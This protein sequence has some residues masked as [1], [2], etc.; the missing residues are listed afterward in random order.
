VS[1]PS[2][3][4][5][6][7]MHGPTAPPVVARALGVL[8]LV[9]GLCCAVWLAL[10]HVDRPQWWVVAVVAA[11]SL[12]TGL[13][14]VKAPL[15]IPGRWLGPVLFA[16]TALGSSAIAAAGVDDSAF[17][18]LYLCGGP[19]VF[20]FFSLRHAL[21]H[22]G[23]A[24]ACYATLLIGDA[25]HLGRPELL[26]GD[27]LV[28]LTTVVLAMLTVGG[29]SRMVATW[30]HESAALL[31]RSFEEAQIGVAMADL[32]M[33]LH[34]V[35]PAF[36]S[37]LGRSADELVGRS[38]IEFV[39]PDEQVDPSYI[40]AHMTPG[41]SL[42]TDA[43]YVRP[44]GSVV[45][46]Q[47][48]LTLIADDRG[49]PRF[50]LSH[51]ADITD[52]KH[53]VDQL[54]R[55]AAA[56]E[57]IADLGR[58]ALETTDL[59]ELLCR[60]NRMACELLGCDLS[61]VLRLQ[62]DGSLLVASGH[63]FEPGEIGTLRALPGPR[64]FGAATSI[65][66]E[67]LTVDRWADEQR[68][69]IPP[70]LARHGIASS[71]SAPIAGWGGPWGVIAAHSRAERVFTRHE[72][73]FVRSVAHILASAVSRL[74]A[75]DD[76]R[77]RATHDPLTGLANRT[78]FLERLEAALQREGRPGR[79]AVLL[80]DLDE[81]KVVNDSL[82]HRAGDEVLVGL[83]ERLAGVVRVGDT[84]ARLG[85]DE[86]VVLFE[87]VASEDEALA[88]AER[89]AQAWAEPL[90]TT[91]GAIFAS[92]SMG[93]ALSTH[94]TESAPTLLEQADAAMYRAKA[95][96]RGGME[97]FD[98]PMR[99]AALE[100]LELE[101]DL[102][103]ALAHDELWVAYQPVMDL[104][105]VERPAFVEALLRWDHPTRGS[106]PPSDFIPVAEQSG[107]ITELGAFVVRR[108]C[109]DVAALRQDLGLPRLGV[110][111]NLSAR[112]VGDPAFAPA[113]AEALEESGLPPAALGIE[114][115]ESLLMEDAAAPEQTLACLRELGVR[116]VL[117]DFGTGY[118][119]L[120]YLN[121]FE[122]DALKLDRSFVWELGTDGDGDAS[123]VTAVIRL[124]GS[125]GLD[126][127]VE[128]VE[129]PGQLRTLRTLGCRFVQGFLFARP[130]GIDALHEWLVSGGSAAE[131]EAA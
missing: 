96:G 38:Q 61:A 59:D 63:G 109:V 106:V 48:V 15:L 51:V 24:A 129:T 34:Y 88:L 99:A 118:S 100:R 72:T 10:P 125:L 115:T 81:F 130:M 83:A 92:A 124:A 26:Y 131:P 95:R 114:I 77:H 49:R 105:D 22:V 54:G 123:I 40:H 62:S 101:R 27:Y 68:F 31:Q 89:L 86:F 5:L 120:G 102:R 14:L 18:P 119:S 53:A 90:D 30:L 110:S 25:L 56:Q 91:E 82:G 94:R 107:L 121:R 97:L 44:D 23:F 28:H 17:I 9:G 70:A 73:D 32:D 103:M 65:A 76:M 71:I 98:E 41:Q 8:Y 52:R 13:V 16:G 6:G 2:P 57:A 104:Q 39:H 19:F 11:M 75:E 43:R 117:D 47:L 66:D 60:A 37:L 111:V 21:T 84:V 113:L 80:C 33:T 4:E 42:R 45:W 128:G 122:L 74:A 46:G 50:F 79:V 58:A 1:T 36:C 64:S 78:L 69:V 67:P 35:N 127:V 29:L 87:H 12:T 116:L 7:P 112:E 3:I 55:R 126:L 20:S 93:V 108:A 85:G